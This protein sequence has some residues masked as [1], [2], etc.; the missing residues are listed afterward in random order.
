MI[1]TA[2]AEPSTLEQIYQELAE[3]VIARLEAQGAPVDRIVISRTVDMRYAGQLHEVN[4]PVP[5]STLT[6]KEIE[7]AAEAFHQGHLQEYAY[8]SE[9]ET[10]EM[11][12]FRVRAVWR[13]RRPKL[14]EIEAGNLDQA[15]KKRRQVYFYE[16]GRRV[17]CP[18]YQRETLG[19]GCSIDGPAIVEEMSSTTLVPPSFRASVDQYGNIR[20]KRINQ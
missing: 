13:V 3:L 9:G 2:E 7:A 14:R 18:V 19:K 11:V 20:L 15:L 6:P 5:D 4:V 1:R 12:T 8:K 17:E 16:L 10:T